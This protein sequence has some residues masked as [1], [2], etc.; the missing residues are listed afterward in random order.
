MTYLPDLPA[1][2]SSMSN[3]VIHYALVGLRPAGPRW[4]VGTRTLLM[5]TLLTPRLTPA[6]LGS[7][8]ICDYFS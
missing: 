4:I 1:T 2:S 8:W 3:L 7:I 5:S 6:A